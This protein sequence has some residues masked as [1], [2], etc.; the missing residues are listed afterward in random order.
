MFPAGCAAKRGAD[1]AAR[2]PY[3]EQRVDALI[4][5][6]GSPKILRIESQT[7]PSYS[8]TQVQLFPS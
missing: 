3:Q 6:P 5:G 7:H 4:F 1:G 2:H 8:L